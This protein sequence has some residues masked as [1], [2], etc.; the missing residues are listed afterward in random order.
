MIIGGALLSTFL[1]A[2][3]TLAKSIHYHQHISHYETN[4]ARDADTR[5]TLTRRQDPNAADPAP[6][7]STR[8][9][10]GDAATADFEKWDAATRAACDTA[11]VGLNGLVSNPTGL[12]VCYNLPYLDN[13][14][15]VFLAEI[16][17]YNVTPPSDPWVGIR[18]EDIDLALAYLGAMTTN[19]TWPPVQEQSQNQRR[20]RGEEVKDVLV[21]RQIPASP[22]TPP[23]VK[24]RM[25]V[26]QINDNLMGTAMTK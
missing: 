3:P 23:M 18:I 12:A 25:F 5:A 6:Q 9:A 7:V 8:P 2:V 19:I 10:S 17:M 14:T 16:R 26:G 21:E 11:I 20:R 4:L 1:L 13:S 22:E 24:V 15:G